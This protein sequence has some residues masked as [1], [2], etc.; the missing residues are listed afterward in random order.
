[1]QIRER[2]ILLTD[3]VEIPR[4]GYGTSKVKG[5]QAHSAISTALETGYRLID[6]AE[7]YQNESELGH[8][9]TNSGIDREEL[10]LT[11]KVWN[12]HQGYDQTRQALDES[13]NRLGTDYLDLYLIHWPC[14]D[15][16]RYVDTWRALITA[17][18]EGLVT[19]IGTSNFQPEHMQRLADETGVMPVLNQVELHP[20]FNQ[21]FLRTWH[22]ENGV[23]TQSWG[24]LGQRAGTLL[25]EEVITT[26]A[27]AHGTTPGQVVLRWHLQRDCLVIP[28]SVN[29]DRIK[30]NFDL[31]DF[32]LSEAEMHAIDKLDTGERQGGSPYEVH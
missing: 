31:Y 2:T 14:P 4:V 3:G 13:L 28:K 26:A 27:K 20:Y 29:A 16:D 19:S 10:F 11:S 32:E 5:D 9:L 22:L 23:A 8:I 25:N 15:T 21:P 6:T 18:A 7:L 30:A 12:N 17:R 24:P 1:M